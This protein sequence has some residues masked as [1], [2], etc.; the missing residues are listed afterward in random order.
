MSLAPRRAFLSGVTVA[1]CGAL[2]TLLMSAL[3]LFAALQ[4]PSQRFVA[5]PYVEPADAPGMA[6]LL[7]LYSLGIPWLFGRLIRR[8]G[9]VDESKGCSPGA[10]G[11]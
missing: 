6:L 1:L 2:G 11:P 10:R 3:G 7:A 5:G 9:P 4:F 8:W